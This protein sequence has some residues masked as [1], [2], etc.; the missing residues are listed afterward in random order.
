[1]KRGSR[2]WLTCANVRWLARA[3]PGT[4]FA[5][6]QT[7]SG[8]THTMRGGEDGP[9]I[10]PL[11]IDE[12]FSAAGQVRLD[13][14]GQQSCQ[15]TLA[16]CGWACKSVTIAVGATRYAELLLMLLLLAGHG[17]GVLAPSLLPGDLQRRDQ[18]PAVPKQPQAPDTREC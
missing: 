2:S 1:M 7:S 16:L 14:S 3:E 6:G 9:G 17:Q 18:R 10:I 15:R 12:I 11:C 8:K 13:T 5:Y 4:I